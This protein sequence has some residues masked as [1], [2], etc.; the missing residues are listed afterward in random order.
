MSLEL[1]HNYNPVCQYCGSEVRD[2]W[3]IDFGDGLEGV[4]SVD[5]GHCGWEYTVARNVT[6]T[7]ST[8]EIP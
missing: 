3:E 4:T 2:A 1:M 8:Y 6:V 7:Y 5:C